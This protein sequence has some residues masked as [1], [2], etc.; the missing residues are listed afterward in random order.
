MTLAATG[1]ELRQLMAQAVFARD[2]DFQLDAF[3]DGECTVR[4]PFQVGLERP[5]GLVGGPAFMAAADIAM[6]LAI[7]TRLGPDD[8]SVTAELKTTFLGPVRRQDFLCTARILKLG[9]RLIYGVAECVDSQ[10]RLL[11]H[12]TVT[13]FR[14]DT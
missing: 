3:G 7:A 1:G 5:G 9:R 11:T 10:G 14:P 8:R 12:H 13:Y 2:Y 6:W 4:V